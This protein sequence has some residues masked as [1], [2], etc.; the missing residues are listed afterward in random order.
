MSTDV[1]TI[2]RIDKRAFEEAFKAGDRVAIVK[3]PHYWV[4]PW[5]NAIG[6]THQVPGPVGFTNETVS[7]EDIYAD[8]PSRPGEAFRYWLV[9]DAPSA[10]PSEGG[11]TN[12]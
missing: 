2:Q 9:L 4:F 8:G 5:A 11:Q 6:S 1:A 3:D 10:A 7:L 12:D